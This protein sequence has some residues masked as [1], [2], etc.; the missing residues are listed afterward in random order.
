MKKLLFYSLLLVFL[1]QCMPVQEEKLTDINYDLKD[2]ILQKL[3]NFQDQRL[4][5]SLLPFFQHKDPTYRYV[6]AN[7]FASA[8]NKKALQGLVTLLK[9]EVE[10]VRIAA[11]YAIGQIGRCFCGK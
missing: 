2:P 7:A 3:Y 1:A 9:D 11:A 10:E 5:D 8:R 4:T 6:A